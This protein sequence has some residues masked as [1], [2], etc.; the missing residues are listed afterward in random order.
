MIFIAGRLSGISFRKG[1][2]SKLVNNNRDLNSFTNVF[3]SNIDK[4]AAQF[5]EIVDDF[6]DLVY[7]PDSILEDIA[8]N[9]VKPHEGPWKLNLSTAVKKTVLK[10]CPNREI[11]QKV[12]NFDQL[13][14]SGLL[15]KH[16]SNQKLIQYI[17]EARQKQAELLEFQN[18]LELSKQTKMVQDFEM[19]RNVIDQLGS[20]A[21]VEHKNELQFLLD[22]AKKSDPFPD[23]MLMPW[24]TR[25]YKER[26][27]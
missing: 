2:R 12:W 8:P 14:G 6:V 26:Y 10:Q 19:L 5:S 11:R 7:V 17:R 18:Y 25:Y 15:D 22:F 24:D 4:N 27:G 3:Q 21:K 13:K 9:A 23:D 16:L 1:K 20:K